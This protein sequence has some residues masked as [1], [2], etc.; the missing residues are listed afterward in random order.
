M[1]NEDQ[2]K[3]LQ[4]NTNI[5]EEAPMG[6]LSNF[7]NYADLSL[8]Y[9]MQQLG[10]QDYLVMPK[11]WLRTTVSALSNITQTWAVGQ[12]NSRVNQ[13]LMSIFPDLFSK[14]S[15]LRF[16]VVYKF[17]FRATYNHTGL[18]GI[19]WHPYTD[20]YTL[21]GPSLAQLSQFAISPSQRVF[22]RIGQDT[23]VTL[24]VPYMACISGLPS[25]D[26]IFTRA[27][28]SR[29]IFEGSNYAY[30]LKFFEQVP[31][32]TI[33]TGVQ[34]VDV[35]GYISLEDIVVGAFRGP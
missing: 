12:T 6:Q 14:Y 11:I 20:N 13:N 16:T 4:T 19:S 27:E 17:I 35:I 24:K 28:S 34:D 10:L 8:N 23:E 3:H 2:L 9:S 33:E 15:L 22:V 26:T 31:T 5:Q 29:D 1:N 18:F 7:P 30:I 25:T 32:R 21:F